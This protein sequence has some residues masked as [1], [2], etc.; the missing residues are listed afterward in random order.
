[1]DVILASSNL[2][3]KFLCESYLN[4]LF[5]KLFILIAGYPVN[6]ALWNIGNMRLEFRPTGSSTKIGFSTKAAVE[7]SRTRIYGVCSSSRKL[8]LLI[9]LINSCFR[10]FEKSPFECVKHPCLTLY[11]LKK[12]I[13]GEGILLEKSQ[14]YNS[15]WPH[16]FERFQGHFCIFELN[17]IYL[18]HCTSRS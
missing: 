2:V 9:W 18:L 5:F 17:V 4:C 1:M 3:K 10:R 7:G 16:V 13:I 12:C 6:L 14:F 11:M 15:F 8:F